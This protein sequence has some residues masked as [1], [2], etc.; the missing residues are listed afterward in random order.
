MQKTILKIFT[1]R[2]VFADCGPFHSEN[3]SAA[4]L[5]TEFTAENYPEVKLVCLVFPLSEGGGGDP[6]PFSGSL[7][8]QT[9]ARELATHVL[10]RDAVKGDA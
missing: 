8:Q 6:A 10:A 1:L 7:S 9:T 3:R 5:C 4:L 2:P